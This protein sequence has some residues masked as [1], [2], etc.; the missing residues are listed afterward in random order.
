M[1]CSFHSP[2]DFAFR[3]PIYY[4]ELLGCELFAPS[5]A[6]RMSLLRGGHFVKP[7]SLIDGF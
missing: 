3:C 1:I 2:P 5:V 7:V 4:L 6:T